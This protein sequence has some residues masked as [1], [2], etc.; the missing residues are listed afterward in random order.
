VDQ[1]TI[2]GCRA[3]VDRAEAAVE[4]LAVEF[5]EWLKT[6][7]YPSRVDVDR[8]AGRYRVLFDF[9]VLPPP[10][11]PVRVG[12]IA[13]D[14][15]SA[16]DHLVWRE[17]VELL[18]REPT[19]EEAG[20]IAFPLKRTR[21]RFE[22]SEVKRYVSPDAWTVI[23]RHQ[24]YDRGKPKRSKA[25]A[26]VHW[27]NRVDKHRFLHE[28]TV[29]PMWFKPLGLIAF[30]PRASIIEAT[31]APGVLGRMAKGETE[32]APYR[33]DLVTA[34]PDPNVR[35]KATPPLTISYGNSP[36]YLRRVDITET[37]AEVRSVVN[38]FATLV[39]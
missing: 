8:E 7:P 6:N 38:D 29:Y 15:R 4:E 32:V 36:R 1:A 35:V 10:R 27:I 18:R 17:A 37:F 30:D 16:L 12:E 26:L 22:K 3:K 9:S 33:F 14:L 23:E 19:D 21:I 20:A 31:H 25:L 39:P 11:F 34:F 28:S 13:H 2:D 24:P 5:R